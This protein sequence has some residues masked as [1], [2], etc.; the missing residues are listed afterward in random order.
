MKDTRGTDMGASKFASNEEEAHERACY[1]MAARYLH[2]D[3]AEEGQKIV[4]TADNCDD[5]SVGCPD[6]PFKSKG[7]Q[8]GD[9]GT[10]TR[11]D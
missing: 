1:D 9:M 3:P 2:L 11:R 8:H 5:G 6:C 10:D 7:G 4:N